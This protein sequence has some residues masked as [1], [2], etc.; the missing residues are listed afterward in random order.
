[1]GKGGIKPDPRKVKIVQQWPD[2]KN[3]H[4]LRQFLGL[5]NYFRKYLQGYSTVVASLTGLTRQDVT[6]QWGDEQRQAFLKVKEMLTNAPLLV[7][8]DPTKPYEVICDASLEGLGAV[9]LQE[10]KPI[11]YDSRKLTSAEKN[12]TTTE[13]ELLAVVHALEVSRCY[14][15]GR[16]RGSQW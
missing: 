6:W 10:G 4:E 12:Y 7:H 11:A 8:P 14:L 16:P 3:L 2:P 15:E 13:Q 9:L 1:M 5:A